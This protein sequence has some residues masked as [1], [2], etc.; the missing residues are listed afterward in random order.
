MRL[1]IKETDQELIKQLSVEHQAAL[2]IKTDYKAAALELGI[3][4]GTLKSRRSRA[5]Q[6]LESLRKS[7]PQADN[8]SL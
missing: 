5:F 8:A 7:H 4:V 1:N 6:A 2:N 3:N